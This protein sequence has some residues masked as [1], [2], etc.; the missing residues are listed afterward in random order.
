[1]RRPLLGSLVVYLGLVSS[2]PLVNTTIGADCPPPVYAEPSPASPCRSATHSCHLVP[3]LKQIKKTV[4][5]VREE[6]YCL[7]RLPPLLSLW[8][9][10]C[11]DCGAGDEC[12]CVRYRKVLVKKEIVCEE[13][14]GTKCLVH[15]HIPCA[16]GQP[17]GK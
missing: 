3:D 7:K 5:E 4:Y 1:M 10:H 13:T 9:R 16:L 17:T 11:D 8:H 6:P 12:Q 15:E 2:G 14:C